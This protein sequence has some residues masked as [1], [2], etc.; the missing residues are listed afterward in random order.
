MQHYSIMQKVTELNNRK[1]AT[2][3]LIKRFLLNRFL[4]RVARQLEANAP[5]TVM[6]FGCGSGAFWHEMAHHLELWP[7]EIMGIDTDNAAIIQATA[8][9][10]KNARFYSMGD[11]GDVFKKDEFDCIICLEVLE[12]LENPQESLKKLCDLQPKNI[13]LS[14][15]NEP[16]FRI[17]QM[18]SLKNL[19]RLGNDF[20]HVQNW[21]SS[22]F[23]NM[24]KDYLNITSVDVSAFPFT[25]VVGT[26]KN[27]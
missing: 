16:W 3:S 10:I 26:P 22:Q 27:L 7:N 5:N 9:N 11:S 24:V 12:H 23:T 18:L 14:V 13:I 1:Y 25:I 15:P 4:G 20:D 8:K 19:S 21:S 6:D 17:C 2:K